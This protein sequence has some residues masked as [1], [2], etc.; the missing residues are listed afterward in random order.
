MGNQQLVAMLIREGHLQTSR[1]IQAFRQV[2]RRL[3]VLHPERAYEDYPLPILGG[4][5]ISAPSMVAVMLELLQPRKSDTIL[6]IGAGSGYFA[7]LL[8]ILAKQV[9]SYEIDPG[10]VA[11]ARRNLG[12]ARV[13]NVSVRLGDGSQA[14]G[15][16][17][18]I[19]FSCAVP[20]IPSPLLSRLKDPGVLLAPVG[21]EFRQD[22]ILLRKK[23]GRMTSEHHGPVVF[24]QLRAAY[25]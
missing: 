25:K 9:I 17:R 3:F 15:R 12:K 21:Q 11:F 8:G 6:E 20:E 16:F 23:S 13:R 14:R 18:T 2:D 4:Q 10:L 19:V 7:A 22:L 24:V 1:I 5:T